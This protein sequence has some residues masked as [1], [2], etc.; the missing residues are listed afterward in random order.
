MGNKTAV[1]RLVDLLMTVVL[2]LLMAY[3]LTDQEI[4]E[5]LGA[6]M[7]VLFIAHH[8]LNRKWLKALGRG[9]YTPYRILQTILALLVLLCM[10]GSMLSGIWMSRYVFDFL[11]TQGRMGLARAAH[12]LC[13]YWGFSC[14]LP[15]WASTGGSCWARRGGQPETESRPPSALRSSGC[16]RRGSRPAA[17]MPSPDSTLPTTSFY[18]AILYSS[19]MSGRLSCTSWT[20]CS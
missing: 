20:C 16:W 1:R 15:T 5:W 7:L 19:T 18:E 4:H 6:G 14:C 17:C 12:L 13:A 8:I 3:F 11:P 10:L 2:V 9:K